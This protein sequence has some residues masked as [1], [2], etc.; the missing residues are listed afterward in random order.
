MNTEPRHPSWRA[1]V[2]RDLGG[3]SFH[4]QGDC[5]MKR[6]EFLDQPPRHMALCSQAGKE[7]QPEDRLKTRG[8][9]GVVTWKGSFPGRRH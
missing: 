8:G 6:R 4:T 3:S 2:E 9:A 5:R 1:G 7:E